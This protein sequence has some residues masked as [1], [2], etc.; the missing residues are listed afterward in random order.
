MLPESTAAKVRCILC[1]QHQ[2][3]KLNGGIIEISW[4]SCYAYRFII[5][6]LIGRI[7]THLIFFTAR[8]HF[9]TE[10]LCRFPVEQNAKLN[11]KPAFA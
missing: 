2:I 9:M 10:Q 8:L 6:M 7:K 11:M 1:Q 4:T 5:S 3:E